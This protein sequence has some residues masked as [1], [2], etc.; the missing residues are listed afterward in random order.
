[1]GNLYLTLLGPP[2]VRHADQVLLFSTR[3]ELALLIY[4]AVE[5]RVHLRKNLSE[6]FWPEGDAKHGRAALRISLLHLRHM[7][8]E[9]TDVVP[10]PH[11]LIK[12]D[13]LA[14]DPTSALELDLQILLEAWTSARASA[15]TTLTMPEVARRSLLAQ[16]QRAVDLP[17]GEFLEGF[18]LRDAP[19]FDDWVRFQREYWQLRTIEVFDHLSQMQFEAGELEAAIETV[20][21]WLVLSPLQEDAYRRLMRLHFAAGDRVAALRA[22]D[23]CRAMLATGMQT[24]PTPETVALGSR[25]RAVAPPRRRETPTPPVAFLDGP[26]L[27]RTTELSTLIK[28]YHTAQRGQTQVVLLEGEIGIGKTRLASEFLAWAELEGADVLRGQA[29]ESGGQ[30]PYRSVIEA[31]RPRIERENAPDDL[32]SDMWLAE[33]ARLLPELSDRYPDLPAPA[34]DK[35]VA[36][37]RL[38]EAVARLGQA[39]AARTPL[40]LFIDDVQ[41]ADAASLDVV[42]Y[43]ARRFAESQAPAFLL[44][45]LRM[46]ERDLRPALVEW[47]T[48]MERAVPLTRL[49]LGPL[50][51]E[52]IVRLL[53]AF[54]GAA[55]KDERRAADLERFGE[56]LFAETEGQ[57]FYLIETLKVLLERGVLASHPNDDGGWSI[58]FT[59]AMEHETVVRGFFPPSVREVIVARLDRLTPNA[60]A[61]LVAGAVLGQ[62]ITFERLCQVADLTER[63]GLLALDEVL[64]SGL[65]YESEREGKGRGRLAAGRYVFAHAKIRA[66]VYAEAGEARRSI[67]HRRAV[68]ALQA[69]AAPSAE[70]AYQAQAAGLA[71][72]A[73]HWSLAAGDEAMRVVAVRDAIAFYEQARHLMAERLSGTGT[74]LPAPEIEHLYTHLGRAYELDNE[75][76]KA[77]AIYTLMLVYARDADQLVMESTALNRLAILAAQQPVDLATAQ[78]LLEAAWRAAEASGDLVTLAE[79]EWNRA[80]IAIHAWKSQRALLHAEQALERALMTG[81]KELTARCLYTLGLSYAFGGHWKEVVAYAEEART[82]YAAIEDQAIDATGLPAQLTYAGFPPSWQLTNRSM[83]VLCLGLQALGHVNLGEPQAGVKVARVALD[84]SPEINNVWVQAY[85]VLNLNHALLEVGEYEEALR[86]TQKGV[87]LAR[88][89]PNPTLLFFMLTVL[90]AVHQALLRLE[91][92]RTTLTES[93]ALTDAI[94]IRSYQVLATSRLCANQALAGDWKNAH[95]YALETVTVRNTIET[96]LLF[97][98]FLRYHETEAL[99]QGGDEAWARED[100]QRFGASLSTNRRHRLPYLRAL[101]TQAQWDG[102]TREAITYLQEAAL[103]AKEIGLPGERWQIQVALGE[104][105]NSCGEREQ[106]YQ[107]F[108]RAVAI[109]QELAEKMGDE[110]LRTNFLAKPAIRRVLERAQA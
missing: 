69:A 96:S 57:P 76:E 30:L 40:V 83:E 109:V 6:Q 100:V 88:T 104:A 71:E 11:L 43:L 41:W 63:D 4:L 1:M 42:H 77:R 89:L 21:R 93:L 68:Q 13:T 56:W 19:A 49:Q 73:F 79:T 105:Y 67:F 36:R 64:H 31:L 92:A 61:L 101:A 17:R 3:K 86:V 28:V 58:D 94:A 65:L 51:I 59:A 52:D 74:M 84:I 44:L 26:L 80:Q 75:W 53:Q 95:A 9:G 81:L 34:S 24:E 12:R 18:S 39:L 8:G 54:G 27:G 103:L 5:G 107:A 55:G 7:L 102:E 87:E 108:A 48:G 90:G 72:P 62:G 37:N 110:A 23:A 97:I 15:G 46:E 33:L 35:L 78:T 25:M 60:F 20:N 32:L 29:F 50:A 16:L 82:L 99:L 91:E 45:T 38:F 98:D 106:E 70:L 85:S 14:L 47:R 2:E 10:V 22:Y 66:V